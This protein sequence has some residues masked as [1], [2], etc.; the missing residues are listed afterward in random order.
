MKVEWSKSVEILIAVTCLITKLPWLGDSE[1]AFRSSIQAATCL[2]H[3][4]EASH[5]HF[6]YWM[7]IKEAVNTSFSSF[8]STLPEIESES[9]VSVADALSTRALISQFKDYENH[10]CKKVVFTSWYWFIVID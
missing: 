1:E 10:L 9:T 3:M 2:P 7:S 4:V 5:C 6:N 8:F